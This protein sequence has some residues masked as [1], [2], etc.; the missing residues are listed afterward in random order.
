MSVREN[1]ER[2]A[3]AECMFD[4]RDCFFCDEKNRGIKCLN[5]KHKECETYK[6]LIEDLSKKCLTL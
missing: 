5:L 2:M 4:H 1:L 3:L 6:Q